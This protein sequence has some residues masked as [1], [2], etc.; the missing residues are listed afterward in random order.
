MKMEAK[1]IEWAE[2]SWRDPGWYDY[3]L[4]DS[5]PRPERHKHSA[6]PLS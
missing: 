1:N 5:N 3:T 6:L 2:I 4:R